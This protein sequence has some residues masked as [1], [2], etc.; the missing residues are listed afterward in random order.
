MHVDSE[1]DDDFENV[2]ES[3][4]S[5]S[6]YKINYS[7]KKKKK[8]RR[9]VEDSSDSESEPRVVKN[10]PV[11]VQK[12]RTPIPRYMYTYKVRNRRLKIFHLPMWRIMM[13]LRKDHL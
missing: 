11:Y 13:V 2:K 6:P 3:K 4:R 7:N 1:S 10:S 8:S 5:L 9:R 12:V